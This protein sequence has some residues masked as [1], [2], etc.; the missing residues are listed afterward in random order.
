MIA[1]LAISSWAPSAFPVISS[2]GNGVDLAVGSPQRG[3]AAHS[4]FGAS[5]IILVP[6][7]YLVG[8]RTRI[9]YAWARYNTNGPEGG[10][11]RSTCFCF[12][13]ITIHHSGGYFYGF[14]VLFAFRFFFSSSLKWSQNV[15]NAFCRLPFF[16]HT[17]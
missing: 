2:S 8:R 4:T 14:P 12:S 13:W 1:V 11:K 16:R 3:I 15:A 10:D 6:A 9:Y 17:Y 5:F 7:G